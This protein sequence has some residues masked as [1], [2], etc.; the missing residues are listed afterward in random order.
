MP[1]PLPVTSYSLRYP[2]E[3]LYQTTDWFSVGISSY[4][5]GSL[6]GSS[7][8]TVNAT[9]QNQVTSNPETGA[10][11]SSLIIL[12]MPSNIQDGNSVNYSD[13]SM[14]TIVAKG[15]SAVQNVMT[16]DYGFNE[17]NITGSITKIGEKLSGETRTFFNSLG[18]DVKNLI[19]KGL[20]A[21]AVS[22]FGGNVSLNSFLARE[23]GQILNP[24]MELLFS[25]VTLRTF[26]FS[27]KMTPRDN[28]ESNNVKNIIR[29]LK[30]N[31]AAKGQQGGTFLSTP[32]VFT[33][34][35]KKGSGDHPFLHKFKPCFLKDMS[36]NYTGENVY[37]TYS[38]G[39]PVSMTMDLT[40][41]EM[42]PIY[43]KDYDAFSNDASSDYR[44]VG[45]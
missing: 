5:P 14:N 6:L 21:E 10:I 27:F 42:F 16:G 20:A 35:Y 33:L 12:P 40:F 43:E 2:N 7:N 41:Q 36:V 19:M 15:L 30:K 4:V 17:G 28:D 34:A 38:D 32:N 11:I 1:T 3:I 8:V 37:T 24:N 18:G 39:T 44:G 13:D 22:V 45:Y 23:S 25:G 29:T 9:P 26:R 31:M